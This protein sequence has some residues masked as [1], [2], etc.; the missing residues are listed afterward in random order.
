MWIEELYGRFYIS[1]NVPSNSAAACTL[2]FGMFLQKIAKIALG[3]AELGT[4]LDLKYNHIRVI[5][6]GKIS[7]HS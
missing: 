3:T 7:T 2:I 6:M 1:H 4:S 5:H